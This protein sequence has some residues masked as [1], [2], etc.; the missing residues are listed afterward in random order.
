[1][2]ENTFCYLFLFSL[3]SY[4]LVYKRQPK[5]NIKNNKKKSTEKNETENTK[6]NQNIKISIKKLYIKFT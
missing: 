1:V 2:Y 3:K 6:S 5:T 4:D